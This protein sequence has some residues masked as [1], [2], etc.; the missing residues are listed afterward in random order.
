MYWLLLSV[1]MMTPLDQV[2]PGNPPQLLC[3]DG[4]YSDTIP[5]ADEETCKI[6]AID[7]AHKIALFLGTIQA[8]V[9]S[10]FDVKCLVD[11]PT[12]FKDEIPR[13]TEDG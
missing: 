3:K 7:E 1:C 6:V 2:G 9:G 10:R 12:E 11:K 13:P 4:L 5:F 8:P